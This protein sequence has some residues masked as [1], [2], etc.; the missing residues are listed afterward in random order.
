MKLYCARHGEACSS[1]ENS[2]RPLSQ[3]GEQ[4]VAAMANYLKQHQVTVQHVLHSSL[5]RAE[6]TAGLLTAQ[7][8][9]QAIVKACPN[10]L[11]EDGD[12]EPLYSMI[13]CWQEDTLLVG[14]LP[15]MQQLVSTLVCGQADFYSLIHYP[16]GA[17]IC[18]TAI[19]SGKWTI[20]WLLNPSMI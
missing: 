4:D 11:T 10:L 9:P 17:I 18:L 20:D 14:H 8:F 15:F 5:L 2:Q 1:L 19:F 3:Q 6:Q 13:E 7:A 16:P 12:I